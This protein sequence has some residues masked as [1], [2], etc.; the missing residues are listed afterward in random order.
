M[1]CGPYNVRYAVIIA[2]ISVRFAEMITRISL[3]QDSHLLERQSRYVTI[4]GRGIARDPPIWR[5]RQ[6]RRCRP[7]WA[8][9]WVICARLTVMGTVN[10]PANTGGSGPSPGATHD[11]R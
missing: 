9:I 6:A 5:S 1:P 3:D 10:C 4:A 8:P 7:W 2:G 11:D